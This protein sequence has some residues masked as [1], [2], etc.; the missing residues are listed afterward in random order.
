MYVGNDIVDLSV[1][2]QPHPRFARRV[3]APEEY[4]RYL[5]SGQDAAFLWQTW[6]AKEAAYK[7]AKQKNA[8]TVFS[9]C[10]F[11]LD[12][13]K[14]TVSYEGESHAVSF[15]HD[16]SYVFAYCSEGV[17]RVINRVARRE[18]FGPTES[19]AVR[20]LASELLCSIFNLV[21]GDV[22]VASDVYRRP[23]A[24]GPNGALPCVLSFSHHGGVVAVTVAAAGINRL[25][26]RPQA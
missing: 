8:Q 14:Q 22:S 4:E 24:I 19:T 5:A 25:I 3:M 23:H 17:D 9:P 16:A 13:R 10:R 12:A 6:S 18:A 11:V 1:L 7:L 20:A 21:K 26:Y 2:D 15:E